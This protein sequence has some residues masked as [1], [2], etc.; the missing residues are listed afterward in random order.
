VAKA[1]PKGATK[2]T[3]KLAP[4]KATVQPV[5]ASKA[6][7]KAKMQALLSKKSAAKKPLKLAQ[8][9]LTLAQQESEEELL[10]LTSEDMLASLK[11][12][13]SQLKH[14]GSAMGFNNREHNKV[15][16]HAMAERVLAQIQKGKS[17]SEIQ[18]DLAKS[19]E[20]LVLAQKAFYEKDPTIIEF[21]QLAANVNNG[22][23]E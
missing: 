4:V 2:Q 13:Q 7:L 15:M 10:M 5:V 23:Q 14:I 3:I 8:K 12:T 22:E 1:A 16:A 11:Q 19:K 17:A 6:N 18:K 9:P 21:L 20:A